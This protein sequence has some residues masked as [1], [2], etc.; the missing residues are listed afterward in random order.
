MTS[1]FSEFS[2]GHFFIYLLIVSGLAVFCA[3][4]FFEK[5]HLE[6]L[7]PDFLE[8]IEKAQ[9]EVGWHNHRTF[10]KIKNECLA[11]R[12][13]PDRQKLLTKVTLAVR[14]DTS[15][16]HNWMSF[17][18]ARQHWGG[19]DFEMPK[20]EKECLTQLSDPKGKDLFL[21][22]FRLQKMAELGLWLKP[23]CRKLDAEYAPLQ[24][25]EFIP[26]IYFGESDFQVAEPVRGRISFIGTIKPMKNPELFVNG[27]Q[28]GLANDELIFK[29][30]FNSTGDKK[31]DVHL[32]F[33]HPLFEQWGGS[34]EKFS[35]QVSK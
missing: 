5:K 35:I 19:M 1:F 10:E 2:K 11:Y 7:N 29:K 21:E 13:F 30:V 12:K 24:A 31:M 26:I 15:E 18:D 16:Q 22:S 34:S 8:G 33:F 14:L 32:C 17:D 4:S 6:N 20:Y 25:T 23:I 3:T 28:V 9:A 27:E